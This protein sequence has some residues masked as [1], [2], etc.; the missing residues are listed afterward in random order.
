MKSGALDD[1]EMPFRY[2]AGYVAGLVL[3]GLASWLRV[4]WEGTLRIDTARPS[5]F[6]ASALLG[7][8]LLLAC[9][10]ARRLIAVAEHVPRS[11]L[12]RWALLSTVAAAFAA[13]LT[14]SDLFHYLVTGRLSFLGENPF[15]VPLGA[16]DAGPLTSLAASRW[17]HDT[18]AYGPLAVLLFR[19][20]AEA[21]ALAGAPYWGSAV[22]FKLMMAACA[23]AFVLLADRTLRAH[24]PGA[25][26]ARS[27]ALAG[28]C[29]LV[30][31]EIG[32]QAHNDGILLVALMIFVAAALPR[33]DL[34]ATLALAAATWAKITIAPILALWLVF[35]ARDRGPRAILHAL[36]AAAL[37]A[38]LMIPFLRGLHGLGPT[39]AAFRN[40]SPTHSLGDFF[41]NV[42][43]PLGPAAQT[44]A[45][46]ATL[47]LCVAASAVAFARALRARTVPD[48]LRGASISSWRGT[49]RSP[50]SSPGTSRGSCPS[51]SPRPTPAGSASSP[52]TRASRCSR[53][54]RRS[55]RSARWR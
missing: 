19:A 2:V 10:C 48:L 21:G 9:F 12:V 4:A 30:S 8:G 6:V 53:G 40:A 27:V 13:P 46:R 5:F 7:A 31:W 45:V 28:F 23:A 39:L 41:V 51:S 32:A 29:P 1:A 44:G 20:A 42:L 14:S 55:T 11:R 3:A 47:V 38:L 49:S 25:D 18:T 37:G 52:C 36:A 33:R 43:A 22:A 34:A 16:V 24:R 17:L 50:L 54:W 26:G 15:A 35:L